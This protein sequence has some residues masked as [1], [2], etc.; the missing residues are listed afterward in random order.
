[1]FCFT[2]AYQF[3]SKFD[4]D[5]YTD[6]PKVSKMRLFF[7]VIFSLFFPMGIVTYGTIKNKR[8]HKSYLKIVVKR[9]TKQIFMHFQTTRGPI[10]GRNATLRFTPL[11]FAQ[12]AVGISDAVRHA[13]GKSIPRTDKRLHY[14]EQEK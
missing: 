6:D 12:L 5:G 3:F 7:Y 2:D 4:S 10:F 11:Y 8:L 14:S 13:G 1:M 9:Q